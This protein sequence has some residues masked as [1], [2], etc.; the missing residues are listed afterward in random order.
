MKKFYY[1]PA[2]IVEFVSEYIFLVSKNKQA[3]KRKAKQEYK[4]AK[5]TKEKK[6]NICGKSIKKISFRPPGCRFFSS[7]TFQDFFGLIV[8]YCTALDRL[9]QVNKVR[10]ECDVT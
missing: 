1:S 9:I 6:E 3:K 8:L 7:T 2:H 5:E 4:K 10:L